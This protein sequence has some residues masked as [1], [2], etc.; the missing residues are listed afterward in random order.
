MGRQPTNT[1]I[2]DKKIS[3]VRM[4]GGHLKYRA[5]RL[6]HGNF[7]WAGESVSRKT[8]ILKV[9]YN[10]GNNELV[11]TN[12]LVKGSIVQID[13]APFKAWY[14]SYYNVDP[15]KEIVVKKTEGGEEGEQKEQKPREP[16]EPR[17]GGR[18]G[19]DKPEEPEVKRSE[20]TLRKIAVRNKTRVFEP[21][22]A[23]QFKTGKVYAKL[24]SRPGQ[25]GRAD[26]YVLE[27]EELAFYLKKLTTKKKK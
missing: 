3:T 23:E 16:R 11:R 20:R 18:K 27:G 22:L 17:K 1:R 2:G 10:A 9:V 19:G 12:T 5:L 25:C 15:T 24:T 8:R 7:A 14:L 26:G 13:A 4:R 6:D 21:N